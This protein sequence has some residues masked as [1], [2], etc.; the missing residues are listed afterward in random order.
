MARRVAE[1]MDTDVG[2]D[3]GYSVRFEE[4]TSP[5]T[6][7]VY[8]TGGHLPFDNADCAAPIV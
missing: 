8:L 4:R 1:E 3:V 2:A 5:R 7:I 6:R